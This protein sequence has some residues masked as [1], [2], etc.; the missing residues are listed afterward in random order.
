MTKAV[1]LPALL[2]SGPALL[3]LQVRVK[4][5]DSGKDRAARTGGRKCH[6]FA[7]RASPGLDID[8]E[9]GN[10]I[11]VGVRSLPPHAVTCPTMA[12]SLPPVN[13]PDLPIAV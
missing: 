10:G 2:V 7:L 1:D 13:Q 12:V 3:K 6:V 11:R 8:V 9:Q 4:S 5:R